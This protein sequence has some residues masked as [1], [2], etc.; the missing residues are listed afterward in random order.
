MADEL[1][2]EWP[3]FFCHWLSVTIGFFFRGLLPVLKAWEDPAH[4]VEYPRWW[5]ALAFAAVISL[6]GG[7][8]NSN[9]PVKPRELVKSMG[10]GFALDAAAVLA[11][12]S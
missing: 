2:D 4:V 5:A 7:A 6:L 11:K 9:L 8:I 3:R 12:I 10:I 1:K